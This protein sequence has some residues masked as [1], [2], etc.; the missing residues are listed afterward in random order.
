M[1]NKL[2]EEDW[3]PQIPI[4]NL[5]QQL[6]FDKWL[7]LSFI[8]GGVVILIVCCLSGITAYLTWNTH[9]IWSYIS[10]GIALYG[11]WLLRIFPKGYKSITETYNEHKQELEIRN[12]IMKNKL[13]DIQ[14]QTIQKYAEKAKSFFKYVVVIEDGKVVASDMKP[15]YDEDC[16]AWMF[17]SES[18][19]V[20]I[21][22][23]KKL[24]KHSKDTL[25][26]I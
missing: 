23:N 8:A 18:T 14:L 10:I 25:T 6:M 5:Q 7:R 2:K 4:H 3:S 21:G 24:A 12:S 17:N 26:K 22:N 11:L 19:S 16:E 13:T 15:E 9:P 20:E 1:D